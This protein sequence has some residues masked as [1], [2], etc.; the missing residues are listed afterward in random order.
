MKKHVENKAES[1][2]IKKENMGKKS[3]KYLK[4]LLI[5]LLVLLVGIFGYSA[6]RVTTTL[7]EYHESEVYYDQTKQM[8]VS[9]NDPQQQTVGRKTGGSD[10]E[11]TMLESSPIDVDFDTLRQTSAD[12]RAW[13]YS[14]GTKIDYPVVQA[15][16][17]AYYLHRFMDGSYNPSGTLFMDYRVEG[18][19]SSKH[20]VIYGHHM[21]DGSMLASLVEYR[22][23]EYYDEHPVMYLNTPDGNYRLDIVSGFVTW[24]DSRL[25]TFDF[26]SRTEFEDWFALM[27]SYSDFESDVE[28]GID[29][30]IV[31][32]STCTYDY[33]NARYVVMAKLVPLAEG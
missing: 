33:D 26:V 20:T 2:S 12:I 15:K 18:D 5:V 9:V 21:G 32:L 23:Q 16:D 17:N 1:N 19:F 31:T 7:H 11:L 4:P 29:D 28:V 3:R 30:R 6:Y 27:R 14:P 13:L 25:Y 24:Y 10:P 8:A 22:S